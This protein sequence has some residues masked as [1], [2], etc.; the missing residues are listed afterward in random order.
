MVD[1][2]S[3]APESTLNLLKRHL[4]N[5]DLSGDFTTA[6]EDAARARRYFENL[7]RSEDAQSIMDFLLGQD[8]DDLGLSAAFKTRLDPELTS[9]VA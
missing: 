9:T 1:H 8:M 2:P 4:E 3:T 7:A 6:L 5:V